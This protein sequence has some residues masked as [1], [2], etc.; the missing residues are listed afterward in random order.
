M[1][2]TYYGN[3][4]STGYI[5]SYDDLERRVDRLV[6]GQFAQEARFNS[7]SYQND[8]AQT[9]FYQSLCNNGYSGYSSSGS[10]SYSGAPSPSNG[11]WCSNGIF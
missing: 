6:S 1:A 8:Y 3:V 9:A 2:Y 5:S 7:N 4:L 11:A 10:L